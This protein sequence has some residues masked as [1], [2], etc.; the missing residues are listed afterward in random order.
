MCLVL[1]A[2]WFSWFLTSE[3]LLRAEHGAAFMLEWSLNVN[4]SCAMSILRLSI[5]RFISI[6]IHRRPIIL[7]RWFAAYKLSEGLEI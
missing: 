2:G 3:R 4:T 6:S 7:Q 1:G 5:L